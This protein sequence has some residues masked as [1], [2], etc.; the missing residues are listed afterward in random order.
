[1]NAEEL[2]VQRFL[3]LERKCEALENDLNETNEYC[4]E[5]EKVIKVISEHAKYDENCLSV[6]IPTFDTWQ[7]ERA[8]FVAKWLNL[9]QKTEEENGEG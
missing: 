9:K 8:D 1:M 3:S 7:Q 5:L 6:F 2:I 4:E